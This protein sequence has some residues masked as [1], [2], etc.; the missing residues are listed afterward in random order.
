M[1]TAFSGGVA[2]VIYEGERMFDLVVRLNETHRQDIDDI[3]NLFVNTPDGA[4]IPLKE[5]ADISYQPGP[6]QISRDNTNSRTYVGINVEGRDVKSLV[7][8]I[9]QTLDE[10]LELPV[11]LLYSLWG[12]F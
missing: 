2:G 10:K 3:R 4:Y 9:Q 7:E 8:E 11:R 5:V 1:E 6:M 12:C